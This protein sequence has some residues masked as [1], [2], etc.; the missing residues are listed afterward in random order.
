M[1]A[2]T[3]CS[4]TSLLF[5]SKDILTPIDRKRLNVNYFENMICR[6]NWKDGCD[7]L[8]GVKLS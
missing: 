1:F 8:N 3:H 2:V 4:R 6:S 7:M 5:C